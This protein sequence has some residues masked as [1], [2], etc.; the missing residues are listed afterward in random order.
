MTVT[1]TQ[2]KN[3]LNQSIGSMTFF[4]RNNS[5]HMDY[6]EGVMALQKECDMYWFVDLMYSH[7]PAIVENFQD[8]EEHIY[9]VTLDVKEDHTA[10]FK[11][12]REY[13]DDKADK[14]REC[15][16][17]EQEIPYVDLPKIELKFYLELANYTPLVFRLLLPQEH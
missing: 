15:T 9:F 5:Q 16:V 3:I 14:Y 7:M 12:Y 17:V 2:I 13:Y 10:Y 11:V 1:A 8:T 6:T 4:K